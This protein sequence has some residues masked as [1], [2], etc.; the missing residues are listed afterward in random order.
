MINKEIPLSQFQISRGTMEE[1]GIFLCPTE[2]LLLSAEGV[3]GAP[4][5]GFSWQ[6]LRYFVITCEAMEEH[7]LALSLRLFRKD[8]RKEP[9]LAF[10]FGILPG[11][12]TTIPIDLRLLDSQTLFPERTPGRMKMDV[13]GKPLKLEEVD[14]I[15]LCTDPCSHVHRL[16]IEALWLTDTMPEC[17]LPQKPLMDELGQ[18]LPKQW[19]GKLDGRD[20]CNKRLHELLKEAEAFPMCY[21]DP[22]LDEYGGWKEK[23]FEPTGWFYT[24]HDG[25]RWW[26]VDP[27]GNAFLS[28]GPDCIVPGADTRADVMLPLMP[29]LPQK[30]CP[31]DYWWEDARD[32]I[33]LV[34][35]GKHNLE[36]AFGTGWW[37]CW[38]KI[39][40][41]Y[42]Y[43]WGCNTIGNWA[44]KEFLEWA[45]MPYVIPL[46]QYSTCGFPS[47]KQCIFRDFPDVF[48]PE[49]EQQSAIFADA[50]LPYRDDPLMIGY[51][52]RNE[53]Q[54][55]FIEGL[56]IAEQMLQNPVFTCSKDVFI[57]KM[58]EQYGK[59]D[60]FNTA[61]GLSLSSFDELQLPITRACS[62]SSAAERDLRAF[63]EEMVR[64]YV[65]LPAQACRRVDTHHLN[66][67]MRY[68]YLS[69]PSLLAGCESFDVFSIN[70]YQKNP[71]EPISAFADQ[72]NMPV[73]VGEFHHGAL[74]AGLPATGLRAVVD[75]RE[76]GNAYRYYLEQG[77]R[78]PYFL[79]AHYFQFNDQSCLGRLD[80]E[81]YN[82]GFV[83]ICLQEHKEMTDVVADCHRTLYRVANGDLPPCDQEPKEIAAIH[84]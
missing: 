69:D 17:P 28:M 53:P 65:E 45:H 83:D 14:Y 56:C 13:F 47:T 11:L 21:E 20:A 6:G 3:P 84:Y 49:Y 4:A 40:K 51:F 2:G 50:L 26:L 39:V 52:M 64:R 46:D 24:K 54:W 32:I 34:N 57:R 15:E 42:L 31:R 68:A 66:L 44:Q 61:W 67:G 78:S 23:Q 59:I 79:G 9:D 74:D 18:W 71:Y 8:N 35:F 10:V 7:C 76:R 1:N 25:C 37:D 63:S 36:E 5:G 48:S 73:I 60:Q 22:S 33:H 81:N 29:A 38:A 30:E 12:K 19:N 58:S 16:K 41:M 72:L 77:A 70:S 62:L 82:I 43:R 27:I 80:G 55:A 75:Q